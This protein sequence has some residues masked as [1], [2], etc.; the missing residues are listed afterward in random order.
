M[1]ATNTRLQGLEP[2]F[3]I[4][5]TMPPMSY[6]GTSVYTSHTH[7]RHITAPNHPPCRAGQA[8]N[9]LPQT[10]THGGS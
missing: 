8:E 2:P 9:R 7:S 5:G 10:I 4:L 3:I 6:T 1:I